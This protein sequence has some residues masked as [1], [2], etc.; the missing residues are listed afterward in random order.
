VSTVIF[1][2]LSQT[3]SHSVTVYRVTVYRTR[4]YETDLFIR[5]SVWGYGV[6]WSWRRGIIWIS[7]YLSGTRRAEAT[8]ACDCGPSGEVGAARHRQLGHGAQSVRQGGVARPRVE[9]FREYTL[10][11]IQYALVLL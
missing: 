4:V 8:G 6:E 7:L 2:L 10:F 9:F 11:T 3:R 5:V 1:I